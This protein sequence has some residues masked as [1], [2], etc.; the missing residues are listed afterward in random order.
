MNRILLALPLSFFL[1][2]TVLAQTAPA[3]L[4]PASTDANVVP[5]AST[6][7]A[8]AITA[9]LHATVWQ[10]TAPEYKALT[11]QA[12]QWAEW[13]LEKALA[14]K[15]WSAIPDVKPGAGQMPAIILDI[16]ETILDTSAHQGRLIKNGRTYTSGGW[17]DYVEGHNGRAIEAAL[18]FLQKVQKD[19]KV[20]IFYIT[21]RKTGDAAKKVRDERADTILNLRAL[22]FPLEPNG[23]NVITREGDERDKTA[24]RMA[25]AAKYRVVLLFGDD[26]ND[27]V[28]A[29]GK[30]RD[31]RTA[32][33]RKY[34]TMFGDKWIILPNAVYGSWETAALDNKRGTPCEELGKKLNLLRTD[35]LYK[36]EPSH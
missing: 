9:A 7:C 4:P 6:F 3:P 36:A 30:S 26:L 15:N 20:K 34:E 11:R 12:Y 24:R 27:F 22:G 32:I 35:E 33:E 25:V 8:P 29:D 31:E 16:D 17:T 10:Q 14:D 2:T 18:E 23:E 19:G 28:P 21:N 5:A 1:A 13:R